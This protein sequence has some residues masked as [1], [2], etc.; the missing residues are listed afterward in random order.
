MADDNGDKELDVT[1][2]GQHVRAKGYRLGDL[3]S[4]AAIALLGYG[5][6]AVAQHKQESDQQLQSLSKAILESS[7]AQVE[8]FNRFIDEQ[9]KASE[10]QTEQMAITNCLLDPALKNNQNASDVCKRIVRGR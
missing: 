10:K 7:K 1:V 2:A 3:L 4:L 5:V 8:A 6:Y 9:K